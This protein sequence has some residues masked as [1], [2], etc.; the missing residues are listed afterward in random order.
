[1]G[2]T[3]TWTL[4]HDSSNITTMHLPSQMVMLEQLESKLCDRIRSLDGGANNYLDNS[5]RFKKKPA[6]HLPSQMV[7]LKLPESELCALIPSK[8]CLDN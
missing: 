7:K 1:M 8:I 4:L 6:M 2:Q 5:E 3:I